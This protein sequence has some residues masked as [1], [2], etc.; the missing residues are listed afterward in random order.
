MNRGKQVVVDTWTPT[1][2]ANLSIFHDWEIIHEMKAANDKISSGLS[3]RDEVRRALNTTS[4]SS[5]EEEIDQTT[6][7]P[8]RDPTLHHLRKRKERPS[9]SKKLL[10]TVSSRRL[11]R[12]TDC[13]SGSSSSLRDVD[14][15]VEL[16]R[17][18]SACSECGAISRGR[19]QWSRPSSSGASTHSANSDYEWDT[20]VECTTPVPPSATLSVASDLKSLGSESRFTDSESRRKLQPGWPHELPKLEPIT[21]SIEDGLNDTPRKIRLSSEPENAV[22]LPQK[23]IVIGDS[24]VGKSSFVRRFVARHYARQYQPT[25]GGKTYILLYCCCLCEFYLRVHYVFWLFYK[26]ALDQPI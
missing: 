6:S 24:G 1:T 26:N 12:D 17:T 19:H 25:V 16:R 8:R 9:P 2:A 13:S 4:S 15:G 21:L 23:L 22:E 18:S 5:D 10:N 20:G 3:L 11:S 14:S 7:L